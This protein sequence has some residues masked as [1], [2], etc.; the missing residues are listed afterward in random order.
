MTNV[1]TY[2]IDQ[3]SNIFN[4]FENRNALFENLNYHGICVMSKTQ[5]NPQ[6][7]YMKSEGGSSSQCF[8]W[9]SGCSDLNILYIKL[10]MIEHLFFFY[11]LI[12]I[13]QVNFTFL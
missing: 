9:L 5:F 1:L 13:F 11:S 6:L 4:I 7:I 3:V 2:Y 10:Q 8:S 12:C